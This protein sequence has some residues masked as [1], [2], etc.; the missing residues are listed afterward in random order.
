MD[1]TVA[2]PGVEQHGGHWIW[3][4][5]DGAKLAELAGIADRGALTVEVAQT[6]P[7]ERT[8]DAFDASRTGHTRRKL[9]VM[10]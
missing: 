8:G 10:P 6:F 7:L 2:D 4:R 1:S 9:V 5:P 3:V